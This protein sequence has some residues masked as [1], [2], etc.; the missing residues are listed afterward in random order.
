MHDKHTHTDTNIHRYFLGVWL[1]FPCWFP[2]I[3]CAAWRRHVR[4]S[5]PCQIVAWRIFLCRVYIYQRLNAKRLY[6]KITRSFLSCINN[7]ETKIKK[8]TH[9]S[10]KRVPFLCVCVRR[11]RFIFFFP[12]QSR[13]M[14]VSALFDHISFAQISNANI[15]KWNTFNYLLKVEMM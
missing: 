11:S 9:N 6:C 1:R 13:S 14:M 4:V 8:H 12:S 3:L 10:I 5:I 15:P 7:V 2:F